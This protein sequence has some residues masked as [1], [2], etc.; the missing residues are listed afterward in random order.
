MTVG[1]KREKRFSG[2]SLGC[3]CV[4]SCFFLVQ[5]IVERVEERRSGSFDRVFRQ[6]IFYEEECN[7][8]KEQGMRDGLSEGFQMGFLCDVK[9]EWQKMEIRR[10]SRV[11]FLA[12]LIGCMALN[13]REGKALERKVVK[14]C[15]LFWQ[16]Q[17]KR[18]REREWRE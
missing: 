12:F 2:L 5:R 17:R 10:F 18:E 16:V 4:L 7:V 13:R 6:K 11:I 14:A 8:R 3:L 1:E 9:W 15:N